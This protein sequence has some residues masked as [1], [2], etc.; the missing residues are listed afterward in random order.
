MLCVRACR[1]YFPLRIP[2]RELIGDA[3]PKS[4]I[5]HRF[6]PAITSMVPRSPRPGDDDELG[7]EAVATP[8]PRHSM[9]EMCMVLTTLLD[10]KGVAATTGSKGED[11]AASFLRNNTPKSY[12]W[13]C[14][15]SCV[16]V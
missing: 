4:P 16:G 7:A 8:G 6:S 13:P 10:D 5:V 2:A 11:R 15:Y 1:M 14:G 12:V 9:P 3:L